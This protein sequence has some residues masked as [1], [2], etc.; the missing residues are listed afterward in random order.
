M[1]VEMCTSTCA[2]YGYAVAGVEYGDECYCGTLAQADAGLVSGQCYM[3][4]AGDAS[5]TCGGPNAIDWY[6]NADAVVATVALPAG[7][8]TYGLIAEGAS[9]RALGY[10]LWDAATNTVEACAAGCAAAG[11][12]VAGTEYASQCFCGNNFVNGAGALLTDVDSEPTM[13]C[14]ANKAET[15]GG[16]NLLSITT[17]L[18]G[19]IPSL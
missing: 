8:T 13:P 17:S 11:Y 14:S 9:G 1:T 10:M 16:P 5:E 15:C 4:C 3:P 7:W 2:A 12:A 18:S 6:Y 19:V